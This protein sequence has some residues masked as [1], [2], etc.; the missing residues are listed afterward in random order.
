ME[1][2]PM[3]QLSDSRLL[4]LKNSIPIRI[5]E[6]V[7]YFRELNNLTQSQ[8]GALVGS[9]RQY[10]YKIEKGKVTPNVV[11]VSVLAIALEI[12]LTEFFDI[13]NSGQ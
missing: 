12:S 11:T 7:R 5:G 2:Y 4:E 13:E 9:D 8:L 3:I 10:I 6:R 1:F